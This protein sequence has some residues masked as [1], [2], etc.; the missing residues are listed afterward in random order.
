VTLSRLT[1]LREHLCHNQP[2]ER[3]AM[4]L[5]MLTV[6]LLAEDQMRMAMLGYTEGRAQAHERLDQDFDRLYE[7][8][9]ALLFGET[10]EVA[11]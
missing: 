1:A 7:S 9:R 8:G 4:N 6:F 11:H 10:A 2:L 5:E 3:P